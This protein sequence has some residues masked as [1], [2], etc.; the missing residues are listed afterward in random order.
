MAV[1]GDVIQFKDIQNMSNVAGDV[2]N[3]WHYQVTSVSGSPVLNN[4]GTVIE[5]WWYEDMLDELYQSQSAALTHVRLEVENLMHPLTEFI[6]IT[7]T[8]PYAGTNGG[9]FGSPMATYSIKLNRELKTTRNGRKGV[10]GVPSG[11]L[12]NNLIAPTTQE[13]IAAWLDRMQNPYSIDTGTGVTISLLPVIIRKPA[14]SGT[15]PTVINGVSSMVLRGV[16][17][18]G[19]RRNLITS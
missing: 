6:N 4:L 1:V 15:P 19:T 12:S 14:I 8:V 10:P 7:P 3:V 16:G 9:S 13:N 18:Q 5:Q 2:M 17:S 11:V